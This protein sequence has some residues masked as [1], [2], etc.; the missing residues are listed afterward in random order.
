[1]VDLVTLQTI[2][3]IAGATSVILGV[4]YFLLNMR[5]SEKNR[6]IQLVSQ[7]T[8]DINREDYFDLLQMSWGS[9]DE[10]EKKYG[11][12]YNAHAASQRYTAWQTLHKIGY[13][14]SKGLVDPE[15]VYE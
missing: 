9:Y 13:M 15:D 4:I 14:L 2:S 12:D 3:Y 1:M 7:M 11:S 5:T 10:F 6:R 8:N